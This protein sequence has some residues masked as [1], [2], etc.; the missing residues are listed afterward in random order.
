MANIVQRG[1]WVSPGTSMGPPMAMPGPIN[2]QETMGVGAY[3]GLRAQ[4]NAATP[5][6][7]LDD[8]LKTTTVSVRARRYTPE[9][10]LEKQWMV[11]DL[12][13][14]QRA[15]IRKNDTDKSEV[16]VNM[17]QFN[18]MLRDK[19]QAATKRAGDANVADVKR[20]IA[21]FADS[22]LRRIAE[23]GEEGLQAK[24]SP[25]APAE[26]IKFFK[27]NWALCACGILSYWNFLGVLYLPNNNGNFTP[28]A[29]GQA[30]DVRM[31][32]LNLTIAIKGECNL[33]QLVPD[34]TTEDRVF[35]Y[36]SRAIESYDGDD[37][38]VYGPYEWRLWAGHAE[39]PPADVLA[40]RDL[41]GVLRQSFFI[42]LGI[43]KD[44]RGVPA[45]GDTLLIA[46]GRKSGTN[47]TR[48]RD[49]AASVPASLNVTLRCRPIDK[50]PI[51]M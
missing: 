20:Q 4:S 31:T 27:E 8:N 15:P 32:T 33:L 47:V 19:W 26:D 39:A 28:G 16:F 3:N 41:G 25:S 45:K 30:Y 40:Y 6:Q 23:L 7:I 14:A 17:Q 13:W 50:D 42:P 5:L 49:I 38:A 18:H 2:V 21:P 9:K 44:Q 24:M 46:S 36:L 35:L 48:S 51:W 37:N 22:T 10:P 12:M 11:G 43:V 1:Q 34:A 29:P